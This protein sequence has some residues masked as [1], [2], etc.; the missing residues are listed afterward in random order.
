VLE[1]AFSGILSFQISRE[2]VKLATLFEELKKNKQK[3]G[4]A[5]W[6]INQTS[7]EEVFL[8]IIKE[9]EVTD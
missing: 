1:S 2:E 4:I 5:E 6:G 7:L 8:K 9:D 3:L